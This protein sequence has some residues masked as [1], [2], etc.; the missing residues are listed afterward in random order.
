MADITDKMLP[1]AAYLKDYTTGAPIDPNAPAPVTSLGVVVSGSSGWSV[2][3]SG[4]SNPKYIAANTSDST[5]FDISDAG[6]VTAAYEGTYGSYSILC[7]QT[8]DP[9]GA[10]GWYPSL[11]WN[12]ALTVG[13]LFSSAQT[14]NNAASGQVA[15]FPV[16]GQRMRFTVTALGSGTIVARITKHG[17]RFPPQLDA[18]IASGSAASDATIAGNPVPV[19][20]RATTAGAVLS[21]VQAGDVVY[22]AADVNGFTIITQQYSKTNIATATT[23]QVLSG[24]GV[25]HS[26]NINKGV[27]ASTVSIYDATSGTT[28]PIAVIDSALSNSFIYDAV[29]ATGIRVVTSGATDVTISY[30]A[31]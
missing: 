17:M 8:A 26:V 15:I 31:G 11:G 7:E 21:A 5:G 27:A 1:V 2:P 9:T 24:V 19:G 13:A 12:A 23:T 18:T 3:S 16:T 29:I 25:L 28:N 10:T 22:Q 6:A 4:F 20:L 14:G 30:K